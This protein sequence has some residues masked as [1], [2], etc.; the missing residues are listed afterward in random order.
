MAKR[1]TPDLCVIGA[2]SG[3]LSVAAGA[4]QMGAE[5]VLVEGGR[6]GGDC[7]NYGCVPSKALI[8][9]AAKAH[10][11]RSSATYGVAADDPAIDYAAVMDHVRGAIARIAPHDSEE[12]FE[13]LGVTVIRDWARFVSPDEMAVGETRIA[14]R[15]FVIA[16]GSSPTIP[17]VPGLESVPYLTNETLWQNRVRPDHLIIIGGG[18]IGMEM[19]Q[20]HRRL[21]SEVTLIQSGRALPRDDP[22]IAAVAV[23]RLRAEGVTLRE[24]VRAA[25]VS[26]RA[27]AI[28]VELEDGA[29][30]SGS[31]LL[32]AVGRTP[33]L[34]RLDLEAGGV[35]FGERGVT[36]DRG[37]RSTTNRRVYAIGDVAGGLQFTHLANY[38][39]GLVIRNALFRLPVSVDRAK[40]P[41]AT[42][43]DPE[44]AHVGQTEAEARE[45]GGPVE[46][47]RVPFSG[48][49]RAI[50]MDESE[51][52]IKIVVG[53]RG[54]IL[55]ASIAGPEAG[56]LIHLWAFAIHAGRRIG[57]VA[58]YV[59]P[60]PTLGEVSKRAAGAYYQPRLFESPWVRRAVRLLARL[61]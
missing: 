13:R 45:A 49:D 16:S 21:G 47:H 6:M 5:V 40:I 56:E 12:R 30:V 2:G 9:A 57:D 23:E 52:L 50:A 24:G 46:V 58:G 14:A 25:R 33:N 4:V 18:P 55:G 29:C 39:A 43:T 7:L 41:W 32:V 60:Y 26:G 3:G 37:L 8:A 54:R 31:H 28:E 44:V 59:A 53:R 34:A 38:H 1:L 51:G 61:G 36:V 15:R 27:G 48:N 19:A 35:A 20:A 17:P 10:T 11:H 42:Y 22:E